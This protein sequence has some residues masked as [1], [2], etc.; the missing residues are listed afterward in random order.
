M[1]VIKGMQTGHQTFQDSLLLYY[2]QSIKLIRN[3]H[4]QAVR[5]TASSH[6]DPATQHIPHKLEEQESSPVSKHS[7]APQA[8]HL[9]I[10]V[11]TL[12]WHCIV[13]QYIWVKMVCCSGESKAKGCLD[14]V[15][16]DGVRFLSSL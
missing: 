16:K 8:S 5:E 4:V 9:A 14:T 3:V 15:T 7:V 11:Q 13:K 10:Q 6:A 1:L 12:F 2:S